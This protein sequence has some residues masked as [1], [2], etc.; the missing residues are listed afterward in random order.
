LGQVHTLNLSYCGRLTDVSALGHVHALNLS[1]CGQLTDV[2]A[3]GCVHTLNLSYCGRLTDVSALGHVHTLY[4]SGCHQLTDVSALSHVHNLYLSGCG[5]FRNTPFIVPTPPN[6]DLSGCGQLRDT[7]EPSGELTGEP[8][9]QPTGEPTSL[10]TGEP[11]GRTLDSSGC[12]QLTDTPIIVAT[13]RSL[14][15]CLKDPK[16]KD[17]FHTSVV[18]RCYESGPNA[19][20]KCIWCD[21]ESIVSICAMCNV[22]LC[23]SKGSYDPASPSCFRQFH[24]AALEY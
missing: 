13:A 17:G 11:S 24:V 16:R 21:R 18:K 4:L 8:T 3:L 22:P 6:L 10:P 12:G 15:T 1:Y 5:Q 2:S 23:V 19:R 9:G 20:R 7:T 14:A